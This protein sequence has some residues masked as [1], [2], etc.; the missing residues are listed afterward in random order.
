[1]VGRAK[2]AGAAA[3][4]LCIVNENDK[5][6]TC[7]LADCNEKAEQAAAA[8][9]ISAIIGGRTLHASDMLNGRD[10]HMAPARANQTPPDCM[11]TWA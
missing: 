7:T 6:A 5:P 4:R 11:Q 8:P 3:E 10:A 1:M 9:T 2:T